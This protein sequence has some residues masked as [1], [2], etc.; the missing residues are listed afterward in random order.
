MLAAMLL[1][2][3]CGH[4]GFDQSAYASLSPAMHFLG[5]A[6]GDLAFL[7]ALIGVAHLILP[8]RLMLANP[9]RARLMPS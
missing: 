1:L 2:I 7:V 6:L 8:P 5:A 9:E 4:G 3:V